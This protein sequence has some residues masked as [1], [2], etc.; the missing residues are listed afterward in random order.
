M[1][2]MVF[3]TI[4]GGFQA[5]LGRPI[6]L[7]SESVSSGNP[8]GYT[9]AEDTDLFRITG[10]FGHPNFLAAFLLIAIPYLLLNPSASLVINFLRIGSFALLFFTYS[11]VAW[12]IGVG[13][14]LLYLYQNYS[15]KF[16]KRIKSIKKSLVFLCGLL[17]VLILVFPFLITRI[18]TFSVAFDEFGSMGV[19]FKL[20]EEALNLVVQYPVSGV[21]FN[22]SLEVYSS[23]PATNLFTKITP[24]SF[25]RIH[26]T[27][28]EMATEIG[29]PGFTVFILFLVSLFYHYR[30]N[31]N[32]ISRASLI[33]LIGFI[34]ISLL[35][36]FFHTTQFRMFFLLVP[37][38]LI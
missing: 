13:Y 8:Y 37:I 25:Y 12:F 11:R 2:V 9:A 28:L 18:Q 36:P 30:N 23:N 32:W 6:G 38:I 3:Q 34:G 17:V 14:L 16:I 5:V 31:K 24:S 27:F 19:R 7:I 33:G 4:L 22:R 35:N 29:I 1:S 20:Y 21:G 26:N 10:S 15:G